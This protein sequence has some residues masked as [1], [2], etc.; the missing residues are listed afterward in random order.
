MSETNTT[1]ATR[2][3]RNHPHHCPGCGVEIECGYVCCPTCTPASLCAPSP[4]RGT[5]EESPAS[6]LADEVTRLRHELTILRARLAA[7]EGE[8]WHR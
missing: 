8:W 6:P 2:P 1:D 3:C 4:P 5:G 7:V